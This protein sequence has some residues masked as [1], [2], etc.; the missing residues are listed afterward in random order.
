MGATGPF[1]WTSKPADDSVITTTGPSRE[2][3]RS[4]TEPKNDARN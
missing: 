1:R 4:T 3:S 2:R